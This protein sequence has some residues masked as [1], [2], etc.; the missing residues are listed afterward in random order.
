MGVRKQD[1]WAS[2][3]V[4]SM[5]SAPP[6]KIPCLVDMGGF[7][8]TKGGICHSI[9]ETDIDAI[10]SPLVQAQDVPSLDPQPRGA[11]D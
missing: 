9:S 2:D 11:V 6:T 5:P 1:D 10:L 4:I 8:F 3:G 7:G